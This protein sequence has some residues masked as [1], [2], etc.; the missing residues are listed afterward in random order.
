M[1]RPSFQFYPADWMSDLKLRRCSPAARGVWADVLCA[2]H[3]SDDGYGLVR[4]PLKELART[5]GA[6]MTHLRELVDKGV[7]R[8]SDDLIVEPMVYVP[9]SGRKEGAPVILIDRQVGPLWYSK[10]LVKDEYVRT[11]RGE[12]T[13]FGDPDGAS[14]NKAPKESP[15]PPIGDGTSSSSSSSPSGTNTTPDGVVVETAGFALVP[16]TAVDE[17]DGMP[18]CPHQAIIAAFH[19]LL[20][21]ARRVR[22]WTPARSQVLRARWR[23]SRKRQS[24]VWWRSFFAYCGK[25]AFLTGKVQS[26][27]R[28]PFELSLEWLTKQENFAKV[29]EGA[30]HEEEQAA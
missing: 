5:I 23:E 13:R 17:D 27:G 4:W 20:P 21:T 30:Y 7:L 26:P 29:R 19:E 18:P 6:Q 11:I 10:R 24:L 8:G 2:L 9:K 1:K 14:P 16:P 28:K 22:D 3:D 25:S 15:K 12:G